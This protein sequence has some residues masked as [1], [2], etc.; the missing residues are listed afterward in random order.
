MPVALSAHTQ[1]RALSPLSVSTAGFL[2]VLLA[3]ILCQCGY[4][5]IRMGAQ[6]IN[7][8]S[9]TCTRYGHLEE[10]RLTQV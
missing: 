7:S 2:D 3:C 9:L 8:A 1:L 5:T 10:Q 6:A 4:N